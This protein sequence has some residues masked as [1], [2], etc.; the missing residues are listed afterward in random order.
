M[1][2]SGSAAG[3]MIATL[4][5]A[6]ATT[7]TGTAR[8]AERPAQGQATLVL[9]LPEGGGLTAGAARQV[10]E[11][12][13]AA[14]PG[15]VELRFEPDELGSVRLNLVT[16]G[17]TVRVTVLAER[18]ETLDLFRRNASELAAEFRALGFGGASFSFGREGRSSEGRAAFDT[19]DPAEAGAPVAAAS[20]LGNVAM[21]P[22]G[23]GGGPSALDIRL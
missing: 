6:E 1:D 9:R 8:S 5:G 10:A 2:D 22:P 23:R 18:P 7:E 21:R 19:A 4:S 16:E 15:G 17:E 3:P 20:G 11:M 14:R 13:V 12:T